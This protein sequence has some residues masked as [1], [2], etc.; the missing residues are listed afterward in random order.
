MW[1][2]GKDVLGTGGKIYVDG[3][4]GK[5]GCNYGVHISTGW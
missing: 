4:L 5:E 3:N 2:D 1:D